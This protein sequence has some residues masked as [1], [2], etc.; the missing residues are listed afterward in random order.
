MNRCVLP[1]LVLAG[2]LNA[3]PAAAAQ[4]NFP[5]KALRGELRIEQPPNARL[6][7]ESA[8]L[9]PGVRIRGENNL[10]QM[11]GALAGQ[12]LV[13]NYTLDEFGLIKDV[14]VL[15]PAER[16]REPWPRTPEQA[17]R[18]RFDP[19]GQSWTKP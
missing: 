17:A 13:V 15:T 4:R 19:L 18:W 14:W 5:P 6:N 12:R 2:I 7:D 16:A 10:L 8:R 11:S 9:A 3:L 1:A